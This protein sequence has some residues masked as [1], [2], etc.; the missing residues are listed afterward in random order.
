MQKRTRVFACVPFLLLLT[1]SLLASSC[2]SQS[3]PSGQQERVMLDVECG[4]QEIEGLIAGASS[5][6]GRLEITD[7]IDW[8]VSHEYTGINTPVEAYGDEEQ[9]DTAYYLGRFWLGGFYP[10][11]STENAIKASVAAAADH[12]YIKKALADLEFSTATSS[13]RETEAMIVVNVYVRDGEDWSITPAYYI[14]L[15]GVVLKEGRGGEQICYYESLNKIEDYYYFSALQEKYERDSE[16][17]VLKCFEDGEKS[18]EQ[19]RLCIANKKGHRD[20]TLQEAKKMFAGKDDQIRLTR[21]VNPD[22]PPDLE[23]Y[24]KITEYLFQNEKVESQTYYLSPE[25]RL[26]QYRDLLFYKDYDNERWERTK[27]FFLYQTKP[28]LDY[29]EFLN[30]LEE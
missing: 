7:S 4:W 10:A 2:Q 23:S 9:R 17:I 15:D 29:N 28:I 19:Y 6:E 26:M 18:P 27:A 20:F 16:D 1:L 11:I 22:P 5:R 30:L 8:E 25:G 12:D 24:L 3:T 21:T 13:R 14:C